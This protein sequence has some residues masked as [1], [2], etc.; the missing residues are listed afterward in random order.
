M[1]TEV[2]RGTVSAGAGHVAT[3][4][5]EK[6]EARQ[7]VTGLELVPGTLNVRVDDLSGALVALG[8]PLQQMV[9]PLRLGDLRMWPVDVEVAG[10]PAPAYVVRHERTRTSYLELVSDVHF[11]SHGAVDGSPVTIRPR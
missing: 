10:I 8:E 7:K 3:L 1:C 11:R 6:L 5:A 2:I 9:G 4:P